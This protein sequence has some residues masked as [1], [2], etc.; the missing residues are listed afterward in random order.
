MVVECREKANIGPCMDV[1]SYKGRLFAIQ[2]AGGYPE[3]RLCVLRPDF[4]IVST[5]EGI[6]NARQIEIV[7][8]IAFITARDDGLFIFDVST[9]KPEL[10][11]CYKTVEFATG[12]AL[13]GNLAF[14]SC[15]VYGVQVLD[16]SNPREPVQISIV[17][18]GEVQSATV[19]DGILYCGC[20]GNMM[21]GVVDVRDPQNPK[22]LSEIPLQGLGDGVFVKD[23]VLYAATGGCRRG[24]K[25]TDTSTHHLYDSGNGVECFDVSDPSNPKRINGVSFETGVHPGV[26]YWEVSLY[27]E[28]L[29]VN[30]SMV[31]VYGLEP[32]TLKQK[33]RVLP[34]KNAAGNDRP[35]TGITVLGKDI[36]IAA[37]EDLFAIRQMDVGEQQPNDSS[38][39]IDTQPRPLAFT[40]YGAK[41]EVV[42][43]GNF[44]VLGIA[45]TENCILLACYEGGVHVLDKQ[46]LSCR[47]VI[48]TLAPALEVKVHG[49]K[50]YV[51]E[52]IGGLSIYAING[53]HLDKIGGFTTD[54]V[55]QMLLSKSGKHLMTVQNSGTLKMYNVENPQDVRELYV[56]PPKIGLLYG[57]NFAANCMDDGTMLAFWHARGMIYTNPD[58]GDTQFFEVNYKSQQGRCCFASGEGI[59]TDGKHIFYVRGGQYH[60][61][62]TSDPSGA[63]TED[64]AQIYIHPNCHGLITV[65]D[66]LAIVSCRKIGA[67]LA[68]DISDIHQPKLLADLT[69]SGVPARAVFVGKRIFLPAERDGMIELTLCN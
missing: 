20:W 23:N 39:K 2:N 8:D 16:V 37:R 65:R 49:N 43:K 68:V 9:D 62:S 25:A 33:F 21:V 11:C 50:V 35:V 24:Y 34:P 10:L 40:G 54:F 7:N 31:G 69:T 51:A 52:G 12:I 66:D 13:Y 4:S 26:D 22:I 17:R 53:D 28:T 64:F 57:N 67:V 63:L 29:L 56:C 18:I 58:K 15:R 32:S 46:S 30:N 48:K 47:A 14:V 38:F 45:E 42:Y 1:K 36:F 5:F 41:L 59:E 61:L 3:G 60:L 19:K 44:P 55:Y 6:G 27:G